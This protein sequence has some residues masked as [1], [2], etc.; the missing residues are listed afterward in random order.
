MLYI[1]CL[2]ANCFIY[3][4][5]NLLERILN[6]RLFFSATKRNVKPIGDVLSVLL[7]S[8]RQPG[9]QVLEIASG[10]GEHAVQWQQR[11]AHLQWQASDSDPA[12]V[13]SINAWRAHYQLSNMPNAILLAAD[14][15]RWNIAADW[16]VCIN[17]IH[18]APW[19]ACLGL[20]KNASFSLSSGG[21]LILYGPFKVAG[22]MTHSNQ[23]FD[24]SLQLQNP[25]WGVRD[26][27]Q[28]QQQ[29]KPFGLSLFRLFEMPANNLMVCFTKN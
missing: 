1:R 3:L 18:I 27:E 25:Q 23:Q 12:H 16:V 19:T 10:S 15:E 29:A 4:D 11:F 8:S 13:A 28:V 22:Y 24:L 20:L 26:I 2:K 9:T 21:M 5:F 14:A 6:D 17:L 7:R